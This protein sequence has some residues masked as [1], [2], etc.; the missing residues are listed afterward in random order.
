MSIAAGTRLG[1]Y[2]VTALI[3]A[4]GMGEVYRARDTRLNR[5]VALKVLPEVFARDTQRMARFER[6]A[7]VLA[8]LNHPN[9]AAIYGI[10]ES[11]PVRAL[12]ME[13]VE[14][15]TLADR[16]AGGSV[17][18]DEALPIAKQ[19]AEAVEYAHDKNVIHR[20]LKPANIKV[21]AEGVVKVL[22]FG[23]AKALAN[24][25]AET[26]MSNSPTLSMAATVQGVILGTASYMSPEQARGKKVDRRADVWAFG[27]VFYELLSG[28]KTFAGE[29]VS[30]TLA[31]VMT[32]AP[33][34]DSLSA[35]TPPAIRTLLQRCLER[36]LKRR[37]T[38]IGEARIIIEDLLSGVVPAESIAAQWGKEERLRW[39]A[40]TALA[41]AVVAAITGFASWNLKP[42]PPV[43]SKPVTRT[44][45]TLAPGDRL[46]A[47]DEPVVAISPDGIQLA[48]VAVHAGTQQIFLRAMDAFEARAVAG[49][50]G[51]SEVFFSPDG[52]WLGFGAGGKL[53]KIS[54][55]GGAAITLGDAELLRGGSWGTAGTIIFSPT[56]GGA[57]EQV[58]DVGGA[59][60][61]LTQ[62]EKGEN[63]GHRW[64]EF[65]PGGKAVIFVSGSAGVNGQI[66]VQ[67]IKSSERKYLVQG[68][69][70]PRYAPS[71]HL[72]YAETGTLMASPF[73]A[74]RLALTG[75]A[76]PVVENVWQSPTTGAAQ[77]SISMAGSLVY[78]TGG[79]QAAQ[80]RLVFVSRTGKEQE[81]PAAMHNYDR[82]KLS[83]DGAGIAV[84]IAEQE[85]QIWIYDLTRD[86]LTR[87]TF[88]GSANMGPLWTP[89]GKRIAYFSN[90]EG[91][92]RIFWQ[93]ADG[94]GGM[95]KL[96]GNDYV[97][98]PL[99]WSGDGQLLAFGEI[100]P[101]TGYDIW[102]LNMRDRKEQPFLRT[103]YY[104]GNAQ[105][106]P[107]GRW[108]AYVSDESG[109]YEV[110]IQP[111]PGPGAKW[112]ISTDG[113]MEPRWSSNG[114][115]LVYRNVHKVM[116][117]DVTAQPTFS[118]GKP[119]MLFEEQY[120]QPSI[121]TRTLD[122]SADGQRF[123]MLKPVGQEQA[124]PSQINVVLNWTEELKRLA[125]VG[126][127]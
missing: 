19:I 13:L 50:E 14:G 118:A 104:E 100:N 27:C 40:I 85:N 8:G 65:L 43:P 53:K 74:D 121:A 93:L 87:L 111:Y 5:D 3:G 41:C 84:N 98:F 10:E 1:I 120:V 69:V 97:R 62:V 64:P 77:Y 76:V 90:K 68:A 73:D 106:S 9:I 7:Q 94:S 23:L 55:R 29:D 102:V 91:P 26:D 11:G 92:Y 95:E 34:F 101:T 25:T 127:K 20:D 15:P 70:Q 119:R 125:P 96:S 51:A 99:S 107:D 59:V 67:D 81:L 113:G 42:A 2:E 57:L 72:V 108:I 86:T 44:V 78:V 54:V 61:P 117:V 21:T 4:G 89:D 39:T 82:P 6:E 66:A 60:R 52:Q 36:N 112:Q 114:R 83:P 31:F 126:K 63:G 49:T 103:Q 88:E 116:A 124:T 45:I 28:Q 18:V 37:L 79:I 123:L 115:E 38:H 12:I 46:A 71:G 47:V 32:K 80:R 109:R 110:Y 17:P 33:A 48:Y 35:K 22:D 24:E 122:V 58:P 30:E 105:F 56:A 75:A 16:V